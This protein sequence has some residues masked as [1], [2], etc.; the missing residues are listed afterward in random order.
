MPLAYVDLSF[1]LWTFLAFVCLLEFFKSNRF[2]W[3]VLGGIFAGACMATKYTGI[4]VLILMACLILIEHLRKRR[5]GLPYAAGILAVAALPLFLPYLYRNWSLTG[6]PLFPFAA[7]SFSDLRPGLNWD[8]ERARLYLA[9]LGTF[10]A[11]LGGQTVWHVLAAPVLVFFRGKFNDP[12]F[13]EGVMGPVFL[14]IPVFLALQK[15][16]KNREIAW[17]GLFSLLFLYYWAFTTRQSR[18]L[19]PILPLLCYLLVYG[20]WALRKT[21]AYILVGI[22]ILFNLGSGMRETFLKHPL[23][24]WFAR[25]TRTD[26]LARQWAGFILYREANK[27]LGPLDTLYLIHMKNYLYYLDMPVRTDLVFERYSLDQAIREKPTPTGI[28]DFFGRNQITHLLIDEAFALS[29]DWGFRAED[30]APF[31]EFLNFQAEPVVRY[32]SFALYHL[33][34]VPIAKA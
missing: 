16:K 2:R 28:A 7:G 5:T 14:L 3:V 15:G 8:P 25:E 24:Y 18:F 21:I 22:L 30:R 33:K 4:Q 19:I 9:W 1:G 34:T 32:G 10:G 31:L 6:W 23:P 26:Y 13:Y 17:I 27:R 29:P 11:P 12:Q 20:L